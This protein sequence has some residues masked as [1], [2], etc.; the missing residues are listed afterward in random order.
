MKEIEIL[1]K[2]KPREKH[3]LRED[4]TF[5]AIVYNEDIHFLKN[6]KYEEIDN[7]IIEEKD[8][9]TNKSN[10]YKVK[11]GKK[12]KKNLMEIEKD[13]Y[14]LKIKLKNNKFNK[15]DV[16]K[17]EL[18]YIDI[19]DNIDIDYKVMNNKIKEGLILKDKSCIGKKILFDIDTNLDL[20]LKE[21]RSIIA[22]K[23]NKEYFKIDAPF[24]I[25]S[26]NKENFNVCYKLNR[27]NKGYVLELELD[28]EWLQEATFPVIVDPTITNFGENNTVYDTYIFP[29]DTN[30]DRNSQDYLKIG[31]E[32]VNGVD[33]ANRALIK[34]S[35]PQMST[36]D[37]IV[38]A[39]LQLNGWGTDMNINSFVP[40]IYS[41]HPITTEWN[42]STATWEIMNDKY[43]SRVE[44]VSTCTLEELSDNTG[45][46]FIFETSDITNIVKHWYTD[47]ENYGLMIKQYDEKYRNPVVPTVSS[48]NLT[49]KSSLIITYRN[50]NGIENYMDY[51]NQNFKIGSTY[52]NTYNGN[53]V[54]LFDVGKTTGGKFPAKLNLVYN[55]NDVL[56]NNNLGYGLGWQ[57]NLSQTIKEIII[58]ENTYLKFSDENG[59]IHYFKQDNGIYK[60]EDGI[61]MK[62]TDN[63]NYYL[64]EDNDG[65]IMKFF[66]NNGIGYLTEIVDVSGNTISIIYDNNN[67]IIKISDADDSEINIAYN[68]NDI[69]VTGHDDVVTLKYENSKLL[70][71]ITYLGTIFF[72]YNSNNVITDIIDIDGIK[73]SYQYY[74]KSPYRVKRVSE[75]GRNNTLGK[76]YDIT[77][78][79]DSTTIIDNNNRATT[80]TFNNSGTI[81]ST[82]S[83]K[84]RE[85]VNDAYGKSVRYGELDNDLPRYSN[86]LRLEYLPIKTT[87]NLINNSRF[88]TGIIDFSMSN[89]VILSLTQEEKFIGGKLLKAISNANDKIITKN[90]NVLKGKKYTFSAYL[91]TTSNS[92]VALSYINENN[93][94]VR[95]LGNLIEDSSEFCRSDVTINYPETAKSD[96]IIEIVLNS[97][98]TYVDALQ[99]E[100]GEVSSQYNIVN[101]SDFSNGYEDWNVD[102]D[103]HMFESSYQNPSI[104]VNEIFEKVTL[105]ENKTALKINMKPNY[106]TSFVKSFDVSG[107][108]G[109]IYTLALWYKNKGIASNYD[110]E[111]PFYNFIDLSFEYNWGDLSPRLPYKQSKPFVPNESEWQFFSVNFV[112]EYDYNSFAIILNQ[113]LCANEFYIT[114]ISLFKRTT[115]VAYD[116]D[117]NGNIIISRG[118]NGE[119]KE[120]SYDN[121]NQLV[122]M[123]DPMG[124]SFIYEYDN[125]VSNRAIRGITN[126]GVSNVIK[127]DSN[128]NQI[129]SKIVNENVNEITDGLY[130]IRLKGTEKYLRLI[131]NNIYIKEDKCN[132]DKWYFEKDGDYFKIRHSIINDKY[133]TVLDSNIVVDNYNGDNSLFW[134]TKNSNGSYML[135]SK[136]IEKYLKASE[137]DGLV[138]SDLTSDIHNY[139]FYVELPNQLFIESK[140]EYDST[141]KYVTCEIDSL[142]NKTY[143]DIDSNSGLLKSV[144]KPNGCT[145][146]YTYNDKK[147]LTNVRIGEKELN[148]SYNNQDIISHITNGNVIYNFE[149]DEFNNLK[150]VKIGEDILLIQNEYENNNGNLISSTYGNNNNILFEYDEFDKIKKIIKMDNIYN[151]IYDNNGNLSKI[152]DNDGTTKYIYDDAKRVIQ[153][154]KDDFIVNYEYNDNNNI[155]RKKYKCGNITNVID[156]MFSDEDIIMQSKFDNDI[157]N[158]NY[159]KLGRIINRNI[160]GNY[161]TNYT[162]V[163]MGNRTSLM[164]ESMQNENDKYKYVYDKVGNITHIYHNDV[165][166]TQY[167][168]DEYNQLI[169]EHNYILNNTI[170]YKYDS[171]G[172]ILFKKVYEL[173]TYNQF[174]QD[175]YEYKNDKWKDQLTKYNDDNITYDGLGNPTIIGN[176]VLSWVNGRQLSSYVDEINQITYKYNG[177]GI[178]ISKTI[179]NVETQ[180]KLQG[181]N[182]IYENTNGNIIYYMRDSVDNLIGLKYNNQT[183]YYQKNIQGDI[184]GILD[185]TYN[186]IANYMYDSFGNIISITDNSGNIITSNEH[187]ANIN[188]YRYRGYYYDK[189]INLYYLNSRYYNPVWGRFLNI[190][191]I[192]NSNVDIISFN[193]YSYLSNNF[194]NYYDSDGKFLKKLKKIVV[195]AVKTIAK[196]VIT[197][198]SNVFLT[199]KNYTLSREMFNKSMYTADKPLSKK[200]QKKLTKAIKESPVIKKQVQKCVTSASN[201]AF[202]NCIPEDD[203]DAEFFGDLHYS[204]QHATII[205]SGVKEYDVWKIDVKVYDDYDF[206]GYREGYS[207]ASLANNLGRFMQVNEMLEPYPWEVNFSVEYKEESD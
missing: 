31:V 69:I 98:V 147:M 154:I 25:D 155:I 58:E 59:T 48:S 186:V 8:F 201:G 9:Y 102:A 70:R 120:F 101:N 111:K 83:L 68:T 18:K 96:L 22:L 78:Q 197:V 37:Q 10:S 21:D 116:Y 67:R 196:A 121:N 166:E 160:N 149:Y 100:E 6:G 79:F 61:N 16:K 165:L 112:A 82:T 119:R 180:Y 184:I 35:L 203:D 85:D 97:G 207:L 36:G 71:V 123:T 169:K 30:V 38:K 183:Y 174:N 29:G 74:S 11:F 206:D 142:L 146:N 81:V 50:Q 43:E 152:I 26:K 19:L 33:R 15:F 44:A 199:V 14:Y 77:Y 167:Y 7:S 161:N 2:R 185:N 20:I 3:F 49:N 92:R 136:I 103:Y 156:S 182:I 122:K 137:T 56:L 13:G 132:H 32:R 63:V 40:L 39:N 64:L 133:I 128:G 143:Y 148:Y 99:L 173:N 66:K 5:K 126:S 179:N 125:E 151:Y 108:A 91:K 54:G 86:K 191:S 105:N 127:Y 73:V 171:F 139:Q 42:E 144:T 159:D 175:V 129:Y 55:T 94:V 65:N 117:E 80:K 52:V 45:S 130:K 192:I 202:T 89:D 198:A 177:D 134:L 118:L 51:F 193:L 1:E 145:T 24:M 57:F 90:I 46:Q 200:T 138:I 12:D 176:K 27:K 23:D 158:Y 164:I 115:S 190:D 188:P 93:E 114:D 106:V 140:T 153:L 53:L 47:K 172:N 150:N 194:I 17:Q 75:Y 84:S 104:N 141:G 162:Y 187:I 110:S 113:E 34:F 109:D 124:K 195:S 76:Y 107:E 181:K 60:D 135:K 41:I 87:K 131:N 189:E 168:Y 163:T 72:T 205:M 88:E 170:R 157:I 95:V 28:N 204:V 4:G 62:I 178:R